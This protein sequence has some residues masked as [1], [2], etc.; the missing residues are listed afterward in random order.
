MCPH[1]GVDAPIVYRGP[2]AFCTACNQPRAPLSAAGVNIVGKPAKLGGTVA[3][4]L[5]WV[6]LAAMLAMALIVGAVLQAVFPPGAVVG[7]A[8]GGVVAAIGVAAAV[9]LLLGGRFLHRTGDN[10]A[11]KARR[12]A[13]Q[14]LAKNQAG[15][16]RAEVAAPSLGMSTQE[17]HEY[18]TGLSRQPD[19]GVV[20][21]VDADG[22]FFYRFSEIAPELPWPPPGAMAV[23]EGA[24][25]RV[26]KT[27]VQA[28]AVPPTAPSPR[29]ED[30]PAGPDTTDDAAA[31]APGRRKG[32]TVPLDPP[33]GS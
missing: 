27:E 16:L 22:K 24:R 5:G 14:G 30:A 6:V 25:V 1:C 2:L 7:W 10:A 4:V 32:L 33:R 8:V 29:L 31:D 19:S 3:S 28:A 15:L 21:E 17:A 9:L 18:L 11:T 23:P 26:A 13:V 20:L 12:D